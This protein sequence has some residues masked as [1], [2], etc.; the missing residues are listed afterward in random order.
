MVVL[1]I[2]GGIDTTRNQIGLAMSQF[3]EHPD[4]WQLLATSPA[5]ARAA[6]EEVMRTRPSTTWVTREALQDFI[7]QWCRIRTGHHNPPLHR[8]RRHSSECLRI[9]PSTS[10]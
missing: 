8:I 10:P 1:A 4:Q 2:F 9:L 5:L 6:V 3:I 7:V